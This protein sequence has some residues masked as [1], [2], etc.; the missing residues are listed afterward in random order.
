M[1]QHTWLTVR[2]GLRSTQMS[3]S[4]SVLR[5]WA[6]EAAGKPGSTGRVGI[7]TGEQ[8]LPPYYLSGKRCSVPMGE[9]SLGRV[10]VMSGRADLGER[11]TGGK[12]RRLG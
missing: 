5:Y 10:G 9:A 4:C 11:R 6:L 8:A 7:G 12:L 1:G 3:V 2:T